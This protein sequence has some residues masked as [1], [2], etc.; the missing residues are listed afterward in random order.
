[1]SSKAIPKL[2][3]RGYT[4]SGD[5]TAPICFAGYGITDEDLGYDDYS[6]ID[7]TGKWVLCLRGWHPAFPDTTFDWSYTG[8]KARNAR[9]RGAVGLLLVSAYPDLQ[10]PLRPSAGRDVR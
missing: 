5:V 3:F 9:D 10:L 1:M 7:P 8:W 2:S 4:G 6:G